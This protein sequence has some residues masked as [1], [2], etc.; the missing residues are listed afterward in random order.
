MNFSMNFNQ[1]ML[2]R[3]LF[4]SFP[5]PLFFLYQYYDTFPDSL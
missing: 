3:L 2:R 1:T 5:V 4:S